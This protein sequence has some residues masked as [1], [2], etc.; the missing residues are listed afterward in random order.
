MSSTPYAAYLESEVLTAEPLE[1][2]RRLYTAAI[3]AV[4]EA[5]TCLEAGLIRERANAIS[6]A[7]NILRELS[8]A[9]NPNPDPVMARNLLELYDYMQRRLVEGHI[10]QSEKPLAEV[11]RLLANLAEAWYQIDPHGS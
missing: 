3:D 8:A 11:A 6:R 9:I 4:N 7:G 10:K 1:L 5:R 2:V